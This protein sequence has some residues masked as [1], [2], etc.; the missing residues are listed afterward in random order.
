MFARAGIQTNDFLMNYMLDAIETP[1]SSV[2]EKFAELASFSPGGAPTVEAINK[3]FP[4]TESKKI[5]SRKK[6]EYDTSK[7]IKEWVNEHD[8]LYVEFEV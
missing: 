3:V 8:R 1:L 4:Q 5:S 7:L 2:D 6:S